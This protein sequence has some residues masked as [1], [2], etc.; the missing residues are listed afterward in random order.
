MQ[1]VIRGSLENYRET[2]EYDYATH[3][4]QATGVDEYGRPYTHTIRNGTSHWQREG[5]DVARAWEQL[6]TVGSVFGPVGILMGIYGVD[7][8]PD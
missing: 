7:R 1:V 3:S 8:W 2:W 4:I 5:M 6:R